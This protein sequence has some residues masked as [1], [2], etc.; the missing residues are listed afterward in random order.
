M[1]EQKTKDKSKFEAMNINTDLG[2]IVDYTN[3]LIDLAI[4]L[5]VSDIHIEPSRDFISI[6]FRESGDF[7]YIDK[8]SPDEYT[9]LLAR[10]KILANLR[11]DE[12]FR[13]Q[14]WKIAFNKPW[15]K[16]II[17]IRISLLPIVDWEKIVMRILRQ[18]H[19][20]LNLDKL[21]FL[22][23]NLKKIKET[24]KSKY[25]MI[26]VAWPTWSGKST[27][28]FSILKNFN[29]LDYN[30][31][32]LEDPVEYN[33]DY[34]NQTHVRPDIWFDFASWLRTLVRQDPD[35]IMVWEIRDKETAMLAIEAA[36]TWHLVLSTIHTNSA[37][38]TIQ[39]LINMGVEP[40]LVTSALKLVISQRL[41][42]KICPDCKKPYKVTEPQIL[43]KVDSFLAWVVP[44]KAANI[45][46][47]KWN[48]CPNCSNT[49][50]KWR[51]STHEVLVVNDKLDSLILW[52][53]S[54]N[55]IEKKARELWLITIMQDAIL[56]AAT[57]KT[58]IDEAL[59]LI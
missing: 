8:I 41:I 35:I 55:E 38:A 50:Y 25:W 20:M 10:I 51:I 30:I 12:K 17:D 52:K 1:F 24:L 27:T 23:V 18:D 15:S 47:Y 3:A 13:P 7:M 37:S 33:I 54:A 58:T 53:A 9:K 2:D 16:E 44:E 4:N 49:G 31:S 32:T 42:K 29:P 43:S 36:L 26:L 46:F 21:D 5:T 40:F 6:R 19:T 48:W 59:K 39:R 57:W 45:D 14:D 28:L 11:I 56:K 34:V 22:D